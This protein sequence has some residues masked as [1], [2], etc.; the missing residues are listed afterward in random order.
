MWYHPLAFF[1]TRRDPVIFERVRRLD[2]RP[3]NGDCCPKPRIDQ[4]ITPG[5]RTDCQIGPNNRNQRNRLAICFSTHSHSQSIILIHC[6]ILMREICRCTLKHPAAKPTEIWLLMP[7]S[8][9][10]GDLLDFSDYRHRSVDFLTFISDQ[11]GLAGNARASGIRPS[12]STLSNRS[13]LWQ[14]LYLTNE[15]CEQGRGIVPSPRQSEPHRYVQIDHGQYGNG[16]RA[17]PPCASKNPSDAQA[18]RH[19]A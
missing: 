5:L 13:H 9:C 6:N 7:K 11:S 18:G 12:P 10:D 17:P 4:R 15:T 19:E 1:L 8:N 16:F 3:Q 2:G 14:A